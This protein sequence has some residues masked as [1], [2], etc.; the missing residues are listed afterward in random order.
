MHERRSTE[1]Y[2]PGRQD[3]HSPVSGSCGV[4]GGQ[5]LRQKS[6]QSDVSDAERRRVGGEAAPAP[7]ELSEVW[8]LETLKNV[9][10]RSGKEE[11]EGADP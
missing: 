7:P 6:N 10:E 11:V 4:E 1:G 5:S 2:V 3:A 8:R 9:R